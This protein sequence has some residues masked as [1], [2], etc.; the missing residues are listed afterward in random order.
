MRLAVLIL[1]GNEYRVGSR[2]QVPGLYRG[3]PSC[4]L[5]ETQ[6]TICD[7]SAPGMPGGAHG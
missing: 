4:F 7:N 5:T 3:R 2:A 6:V 1:E